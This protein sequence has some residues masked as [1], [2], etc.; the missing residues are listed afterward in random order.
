MA[1]LTGIKI[2]ARIAPA[3]LVLA[4][5]TA[6]FR[7]V[8]HVVNREGLLGSAGGPS[9]RTRLAA[10]AT[11]SRRGTCDLNFMPNMLAQHRGIPL[12]LIGR[13]GVGRESVAP[14]RT[15]EASLYCVLACRRIPG[16][17][18][19]RLRIFLGRQPC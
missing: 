4:R 7:N 9:V 18:R 8:F 16:L 10:R 19:T 5:I 1:N 2:P 15:F 11:S 17:G 14:V 6:S 3:Y 13:S 12:Q